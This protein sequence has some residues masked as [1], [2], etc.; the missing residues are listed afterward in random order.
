MILTHKGL[1]RGLTNQALVEA[2][3][4]V[5]LG[6]WEQSFQVKNKN[7]LLDMSNFFWPLLHFHSDFRHS[8]CSRMK[9]T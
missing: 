7:S 6:G 4:E 2:S 5:V 1:K 8:W 3:V 9:I